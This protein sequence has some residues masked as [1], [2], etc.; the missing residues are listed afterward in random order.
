MDDREINL[1]WEQHCVIQRK[2][3]SVGFEVLT[4]VTMKGFIVW[5]VTPCSLVE[6]H[7]RSEGTY[8]QVSSKHGEK[9]KAE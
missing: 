1:S 9:Q 5:D 3:K 7:K 4:A 8:S 2:S 6:V